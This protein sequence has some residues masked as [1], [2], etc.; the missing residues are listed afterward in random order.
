[1]KRLTSLLLAAVIASTAILGGCNNAK[2]NEKPSD[3][4]LN[5]IEFNAD[6]EKKLSEI[7]PKTELDNEILLNVSGV[8]VSAALLR[9][10]IIACN[11]SSMG[12]EE[13]KQQEIDSFFRANAFVVNKAA[14]KGMTISDE[15]FKTNFADVYEQFKEQFGDELESVLEMYT[16]Q[17]PYAYLL[18]SYYNYLYGKLFEEYSADQEVISSARAATLEDM[19]TSE[20]PYVRAKH[21][22]I[23]F[24][25]ESEDGSVTDA[26]KQ[27]TLKKAQ[28][29]L[30]LVENG[31]DFDSLIKEYGEDPG[32]NTYTG[33]YYFTTGKMVP[34][35]EEASFALKEGKT[36][37]L[38]ETSYGYHIIQRLPLDDDAILSTD[39]YTNKCYE[40]FADELDILSADYTFTY[41]ENYQ[42]RCADFLAEYEEMMNPTQE[43]ADEHDH[44][45][46]ETD[47]A[48]EVPAE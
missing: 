9:Y 46:E 21:I 11:Y 14:E 10:A 32:M 47:A 40:L 41:S 4:L 27:E 37:G 19:L 20:T 25:E 43:P 44:E 28:D 39:E 18:T 29:V 12:T 30:A 26:Q 22:L 17:T 24:P 16:F 38:V 42:E 6:F 35:F 34:E 7:V 33:G 48:E 5:N 31:E 15:E 45:S 3:A 8:P 23:S 36:S 2:T 13:E 1:M